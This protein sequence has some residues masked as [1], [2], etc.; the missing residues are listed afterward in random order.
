VLHAAG[1][2]DAALDSSGL[3][4]WGDPGPGRWLTVYANARHAFIVIAGRRFDT[5]GRA[6]TGSR[7]QDAPRDS[8][9]FTVRHPPGL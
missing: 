3:A 6:A 4:A 7:W 1:L 8:T 5:T 9:A 2:L